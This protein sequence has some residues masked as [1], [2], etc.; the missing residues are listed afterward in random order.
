[1]GRLNDKAVLITG[2]GKGIGREAALLFAREGASVTIADVDAEGGDATRGQIESLGG[3]AVF[4][5][6]DITKPEDVQSTVGQ[7]VAA[8]GKIDVLYNNAGGS[9]PKDG[10]VVDASI[11]EFWRVINV[12]LFGTWLCCRFAIPEI[13]KSGGGS[14]VNMVSNVALMGI[15]RMSAY[16]TA[17]GGIAS[18]TRAMAVDFAPSVRVN[19]I[20]PSVTLTDRLRKRL[21]NDPSVQKMAAAHLVGLAEPVDIAHAALYLASEESRMITGQILRVDSG[22]TIV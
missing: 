16:T 22:I 2:A 6:T 21:E 5:R 11:D 1:M 20:A 17:K 10:T 8:F 4:L 9:S 15:A 19:A 7:A 13:M 12:D 3:K 14:V 18:L